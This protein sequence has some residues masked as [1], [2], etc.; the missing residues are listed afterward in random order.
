MQSEKYR[1]YKKTRSR[2]TVWL[3]TFLV[4]TIFNTKL[5]DTI[6]GKKVFTLDP[7]LALVIIA[8]FICLIG[9]YKEAQKLPNIELKRR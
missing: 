1:E 5:Y 6:T 7:L 4:L 8:Q 2:I 9:L 3:I